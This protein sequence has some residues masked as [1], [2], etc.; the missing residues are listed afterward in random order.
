MAAARPDF[1]T[2]LCETQKDLDRCMAIRLE[3]FVEEQ[4]YSVDDE[5]DESVFYVSSRFTPRR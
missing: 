4:G 2:L 5:R 1:T 3:V